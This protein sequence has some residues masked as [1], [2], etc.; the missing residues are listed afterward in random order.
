VEFASGCGTLRTTT[1]MSG[2]YILPAVGQ[3]TSDHR[4]ELT[5]SGGS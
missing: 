3:A 5:R 1:D 2:N 4:F